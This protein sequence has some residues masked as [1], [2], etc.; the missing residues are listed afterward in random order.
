MT[1]PKEIQAEPT[2]LLRRLITANVDF[3]L[4]YPGMTVKILIADHCRSQILAAIPRRRVWP[5]MKVVRINV[6]KL[7]IGKLRFLIIA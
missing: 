5:Q 1:P 4:S 3:L 2:S 7:R 6:D